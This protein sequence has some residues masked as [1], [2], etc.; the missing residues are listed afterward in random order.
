MTLQIRFQD[1]LKRCLV[2]LQADG[3][4]ANSPADQALPAGLV[5]TISQLR[6]KTDIVYPSASYVS[7]V[8]NLL[9]NDA[10]GAMF[11]VQT[12]ES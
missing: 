5:S 9:A 6:V 7:A 12:L 3:A 11:A 8:D 2:N 4:D 1:N 10:V